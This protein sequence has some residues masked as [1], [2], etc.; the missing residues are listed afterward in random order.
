MGSVTGKNYLEREGER[1]GDGR[2]RAIISTPEPGL[3]HHTS[4]CKPM[5]VNKYYSLNN[6]DVTIF[7]GEMNTRSSVVVHQVHRPVFQQMITQSAPHQ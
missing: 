4:V 6:I 7:G 1:E 2:K 5:T 3:N